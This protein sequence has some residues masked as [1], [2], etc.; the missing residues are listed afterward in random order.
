MT[1]QEKLI[2]AHYK[3]RLRFVAI[4]DKDGLKDLYDCSFLTGKL[5]ENCRTLENKLSS[6][7]KKKSKIRKSNGS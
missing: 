4:N 7:K 6:V 3:L 1:L 5:F 2:N